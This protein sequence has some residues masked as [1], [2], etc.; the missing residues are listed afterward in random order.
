MLKTIVTNV[1]ACYN[2]AKA[3]NFFFFTLSREFRRI[4]AFEVETEKFYLKFSKNEKQV[5][6]KN[7]RH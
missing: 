2:V 5:K 4:V 7:H 1:L 6:K 3:S